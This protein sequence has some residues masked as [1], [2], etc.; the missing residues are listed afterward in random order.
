MMLEGEKKTFVLL[1]EDSCRKSR[2]ANLAV[3]DDD[4]FSVP[5][6]INSVDFL[7]NGHG[8][9]ASG[10][11]GFDGSRLNDAEAW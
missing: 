2:K 3:G 8:M 10:R 11:R 6:E 1:V 7:V 5:C 4:A 9:E